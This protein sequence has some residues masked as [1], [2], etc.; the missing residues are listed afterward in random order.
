MLDRLTLQIAAG[1]LFAA[2]YSVGVFELG[3]GIG[4]VESSDFIHPHQQ[5]RSLRSR[6]LHDCGCHAK[7]I[8]GHVHV[9]KTG[10][11]SINGVAANKF[12]RVC[13]HKGYSY[14]AY[15]DNVKAA[16][17]AARGGTP[18][19]GGRS[20]VMPATMVEIGFDDCDWVSHEIG[21]NWCKYPRPKTK[22]LSAAWAWFVSATR[23]QPD[24]RCMIVC[25]SYSL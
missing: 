3:R 15:K 12:E 16:N 19:S 5:L 1:V 4:Q 10:G 21:Y 24:M 25:L 13:G 22:I 7:K 6:S 23:Y 11:T 17:I 14:D 8:F 18:M 2:I 9:A 20:R